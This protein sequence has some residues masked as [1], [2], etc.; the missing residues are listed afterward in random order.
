MTISYDLL[1]K[2]VTFCCLTT[3]VLLKETSAFLTKPLP[4]ELRTSV[5]HTQ[6]RREV[7]TELHGLHTALGPQQGTSHI[8][9]SVWTKTTLFLT[10][11]V[12]LCP[13]ENQIRMMTQDIES[14][15]SFQLSLG[16]TLDREIITSSYQTVIINQNSKS[17]SNKRDWYI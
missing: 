16:Q 6:L 2:E 12:Y 8:P 9:Q 15:R 17:S 10:S 1:N 4:L 14:Q 13:P 11:A 3:E 7:D 5:C